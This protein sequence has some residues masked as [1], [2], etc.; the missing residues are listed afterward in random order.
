[1]SGMTQYNDVQQISIDRARWDPPKARVIDNTLEKSR[2]FFAGICNN[3]LQ[4]A[5]IE[6]AA[7]ELIGDYAMTGDPGEYDRIISMYPAAFE[8]RYN[9]LDSTDPVKKT[10]IAETR[11]WED[12]LQESKKC[13][14]KFTKA[15]GNEVVLAV[16]REHSHDMKGNNTILVDAQDAA[17]PFRR[18]EENPGIQQN[19]SPADNVGQPGCDNSHSGE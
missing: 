12:L 13:F 16:I 18:Q 10:R 4:E 1:M 9:E 2:L 15:P 19:D 3:S 17:N 6:L 7:K 5:Y 11:A 14:R 8:K